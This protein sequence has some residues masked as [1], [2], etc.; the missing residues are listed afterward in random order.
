MEKLVRIYLEGGVIQGVECPK[1]V[2]VE[3]FDLDI[4]GIEPENIV[5][6]PQ[7]EDCAYQ[8]WLP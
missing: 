8:E 3:V 7:G 5:K 1:G 4:E 2:R 6:S